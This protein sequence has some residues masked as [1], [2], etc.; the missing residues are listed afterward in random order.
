MKK[1]ILVFIALTSCFLSENSFSQSGFSW[2]RVQVGGN[3][4]ASFGA[5]ETLVAVSPNIGYHVTERLTLGTGVIYQFYRY[6]NSKY[7]F[8]FSNY[9]AKLFGTFQLNDFLILHTEYESLNLEYI[10]YN[11]LGMP[12]GTMRRTIGS[13]F[14]GGGYRQYMSS[15]SVFDI[16]LLYNLTETPYTRYDNPMIRV[17]FSFGL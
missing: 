5:F 13:M 12:D 17:G 11:N 9:G 1:H 3:F 4:G 6:K 2:D 10:K 16:M 14:V 7:D 8:K 15:N